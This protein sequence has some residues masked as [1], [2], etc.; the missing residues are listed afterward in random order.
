VNTNQHEVCQ[1]FILI[2]NIS[3][4]GMAKFFCYLSQFQ[5][6]LKAPHR[7]KSVPKKELKILDSAT[8]APGG[9]ENSTAC[10]FFAGTTTTDF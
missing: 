10:L 9:L 4:I 2:L 1:E 5:N 8:V 3:G 7:R 6:Y